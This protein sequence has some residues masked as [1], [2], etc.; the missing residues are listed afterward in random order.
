MF[1]SNNFTVTLL[2]VALLSFVSNNASAEP[3][4]AVT[5]AVQ[6]ATPTTEAVSPPAKPKTQ[7][8]LAPNETV[9]Y[10][11]N[12]HCK[13]CA[14]KI[15]SKLYTVKGVKL[16]RTDLKANVAIVTPQA[17]KKLDPLALWKAAKESKF[18]AIKLEG[19]SGKYVA[20]PKT[21]AA[22]LVPEKTVT[23]RG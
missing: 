4:T 14:K 7:L 18:P 3:A 2:V 11:K 6:T 5:T 10:V 8:K 17:K 16:V 12:M 9:I 20:D 23:P 1:Y 19:P 22:Q 21:Q 13:H 15:A